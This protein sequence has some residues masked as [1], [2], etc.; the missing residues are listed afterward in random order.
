VRIRHP[1]AA[2]PPSMAT[3]GN[4][5]NRSPDRYPDVC[6]SERVPIQ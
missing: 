6:G 3:S 2:R 5:L 1:D 4:L